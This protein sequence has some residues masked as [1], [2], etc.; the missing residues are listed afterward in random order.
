MLSSEYTF[1]N[2][3][4]ARRKIYLL[5]RGM[6]VESALPLALLLVLLVLILSLSFLWQCF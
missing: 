3:K 4:S 5:I 6:L 1:I 2:P